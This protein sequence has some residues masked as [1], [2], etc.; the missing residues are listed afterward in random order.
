MPFILN[1]SI[2]IVKNKKKRFVVIS[3][4]SK[5]EHNIKQIVG[6]IGSKDTSIVKKFYIGDTDLLEAALI[7]ISGLVNKDI[8]DRDILNPLMLHVHENLNKKKHIAEYLCKKY[9][10]VSSTAVESDINNAISIVKTGKTL[11]LLDGVEEYII[12]DTSEAKARSIQEPENESALRGPREGFV[13]NIDTNISLIRVKI[14]DRYMTV[15]KMNVGRRSQSELA[16]VYIDDIVNKDVIKSIRNRIKAI[17]VDFVT[18]TGMIE[19][20]I[21]SNT[22]TIFPQIYST[23]RPDKVVAFLME[24][25]VAIILNG[26]PYV[27]VAPVMMADF[28]HTVEDYYQRTIVS[29]AIRGL[30]ILATLIVVFLPSIYLTLIKFN[31]ELIPIAFIVPIAQSRAGIPLTP[32]LEILILDILLEFLREGGLRL[33]TKIAQ[34]LSIVGGIIIGN[35]AVESKIV[36]PTTL[37]IIGITVVASFLIPNNE[38][39]LSIRFLRFPMLALANVMGIFGIAAGSFFLIS[40][41]SSLESFGVPYFTFFKEDF[42]D[43]IIRAPLW[44]MDKRPVFISKENRKRQSSFR[45]FFRGKGNG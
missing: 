34:T 15:E 19:Q 25:R 45:K 37:L 14:K 42:K 2:I 40:H 13:E 32:F 39:S 18:C 23:E 30:R 5:F 24:G 8:I 44:Q 33:P 21:E 11:L 10:A 43:I 17:D 41:L 22:F 35:M 38:M 3:M 6:S 4:I 7:Y 31:N 27:I 29:N 36:S 26:A 20:Y 12:V 1:K 16:I 28:F 9:I